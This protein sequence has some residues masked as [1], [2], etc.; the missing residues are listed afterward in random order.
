M[1]DGLAPITAYCMKW[2]Q[3]ARR[4]KLKLAWSIG[5]M[6]KQTGIST[7]ELLITISISAGFVVGILQ[8]GEEVKT[9]AV[10]YQQQTDVKEALKR[11]RGEK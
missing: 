9:V 3:A 5:K 6:T 11:I 4:R 1:T 7:I 2:T 8:M 10:E